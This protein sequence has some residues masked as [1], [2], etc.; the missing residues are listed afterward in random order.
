[1]E[2]VLDRAKHYSNTFPSAEDA[3][4]NKYS[5]KKPQ[6]HTGKTKIDRN[7]V[8]YIHTKILIL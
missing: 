6:T 1:M 4:K 8:F 5:N 3:T 2:Y 7:L